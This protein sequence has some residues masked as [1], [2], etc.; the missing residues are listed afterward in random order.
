MLAPYVSSRQIN[1]LIAGLA[2]ASRFEFGSNT[3]RP[4][5]ARSYWDA[6]VVGLIMAV[7]L[8]VLGSL[9]SIFAGIR[10]RRVEVAEG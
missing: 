9:W 4:G 1:G 10:A 3:S 8:I 5:I 6:F 2:E 7:V